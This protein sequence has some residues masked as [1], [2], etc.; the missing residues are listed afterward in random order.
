MSN[1]KENEIALAKKLLPFFVEIAKLYEFDEEVNDDM[2]KNFTEHWFIYLLMAIAS[3]ESRFGLL[4][5]SDGTGDG[6][7]GRGIMQI[8]DRSHAEWIENH[9]WQD[10]AENIEYAADVWLDNYNYFC[11]HFDLIEDNLALVWAATAAYNCGA[12][13]VKKALTNGDDVDSRT[14]GRDYSADV[15]AR[16]KFLVSLGLIQ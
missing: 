13:N 1:L 4:L 6:G 8:D 2:S 9:D 16:M 3:R 7:H 15:R 5:D 12:G 11:D 10:P 14:T